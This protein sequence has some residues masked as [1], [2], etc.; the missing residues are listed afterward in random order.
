MKNVSAVQF[1]GVCCVIRF[2]R[3]FPEIVSSNYHNLIV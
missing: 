2:R 1:A 3:N